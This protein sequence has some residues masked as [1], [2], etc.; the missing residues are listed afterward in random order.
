MPWISKS[1]LETLKGVQ[2]EYLAW[3]KYAAAGGDYDDFLQSQVFPK[4]KPVNNPAR[5]PLCGDDNWHCTFP[6]CGC[7]R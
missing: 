7:N 2:A 4:D 3:I 6:E 5:V 1:E